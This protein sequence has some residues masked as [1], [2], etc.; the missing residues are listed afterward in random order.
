[1]SSSNHRRLWA[2]ILGMG[3]VS[4][5]VV[6]RLVT[7]QLVE[8]E[9]LAELGHLIQTQEVV[10]R[11]TRGIIYDRNMAILAG[12]TND[13]RV[14]VSPSLVTEPEAVAG[15]LA[16]LLQIARHEILLHLNSDRPYELLAGR[17]EGAVADAIRE[18]EYDGIQLDPLPRRI[19]PQGDLAC[20][21]LGYTDFDGI[22][23]GGVEGYY[24]TELAG[25][26]AQAEM[27]ISPLTSQTSVI[28][29]EGADLILTIDRS[30][31][32]TVEEHLRRALETYQAESGSIIVM[33]PRTGA[34]LAMANLPCF[35]PYAYYDADPALLTNPAVSQQ[36]E[37]GS[38]MKL[39]TMASALDSGTVNPQTTYYDSGTVVLGGWPLYNWDRSARGTV[40]MTGLLAHSLNVG[41]ATIASWMGPETQ[42]SYFGRF[43]FGRP[44]GIDLM[45]EASGQLLLPGDANWTETNIGTNAFGQGIAST[46]LQMLNSAAALANDGKMMQPYVVQ[47]I[48]TA[49]RVINREPTIISRPVS[50]QTADQVTAMAINA[51]RTEV[52]GAQVEGYT[53]AGKT[54]TAQIP[55]GGIYHPSDTIASFIGWLPADDPEIIVIVKLDRPRAS[56]WGSTTAAPAFAEMVNDLVGL[57]NIPPDSVRLQGEVLAA[58]TN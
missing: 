4:L 9:E 37:P 7:F 34:I 38:V 56:P 46:E 11:P 28:A 25:E 42:Y 44:S 54:G 35:S 18:L 3:V 52:F 47:Q 21:V 43:G 2:V 55:E 19:Y 16:P 12:N 45:S 10:A 50:E 6:Y 5:L 51:V 29:R 27:N 14:G 13:Y 22:G 8:D 41:A 20:H 33:D 48:R 36:Y 24:Q 58:R 57:L 17:V 1:M 32:Y 31:Q 30:V 15:D 23:G 40:D 26:A 53:V 49:D 39:V